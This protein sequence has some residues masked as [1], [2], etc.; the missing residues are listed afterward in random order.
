MDN[1]RKKEASGG[2]SVEA[3]LERLD[4][5]ERYVA[6][7]VLGVPGAEARLKVMQ[8]MATMEEALVS[9]E[10]DISTL[11]KAFSQVRESPLLREL[12]R[13]VILPLGNRM[14][15]GSRAEGAAGLRLSSLQKLG[16]TRSNANQTLLQYVASKLCLAGSPIV[17]MPDELDG[18]VAASRLSMAGIAVTLN[19]VKQ[20]LLLVERE[21][22]KD[23]RL[24]GRLAD[25]LQDARREV[26]CLRTSV[27]LPLHNV[28]LPC[29]TCVLSRSMQP[30]SVTTP[31]SLLSRRPQH[32]S[33]NPQRQRARYEQDAA[34]R[35]RH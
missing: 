3:A 8:F 33:A 25:F 10:V 6:V 1:V 20:G 9:L 28:T 26:R 22:S 21:A 34:N 4:L 16:A 19:D 24:G 2:P 27:T 15:E 18:V 29:N 30:N 32:T 35:K 17:N 12:L 13:D 7:V 23:E 31:W 5:P 14:N 11:S